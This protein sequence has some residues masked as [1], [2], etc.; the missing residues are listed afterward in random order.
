[1]KNTPLMIT[2]CHHSASLVMSICDLGTG[3]TIQFSSNCQ[4]FQKYRF[5]IFE[6]KTWK[7]PPVVPEYA[8]MRQTYDK[9]TSLLTIQWR[10]GSTSCSSIFYLSHRLVEV[11]EINRINQSLLFFGDSKIPPKC[12]PFQW[13]TW[14]A[15]LPTERW[16]QNLPVTTENLWLYY[17]SHKPILPMATHCMIFYHMTSGLGVK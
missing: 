1:M 7:V 5:F 2:N 4:P 3:L 15:E 17:F 9:V 6:I 13:K 10:H 16:T 14:L 8:E 11:C 12:P